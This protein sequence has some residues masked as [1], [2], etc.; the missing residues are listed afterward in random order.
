MRELTPGQHQA[1]DELLAAHVLRSLDGEDEREAERLLAEHVP[2]CDRCRRVLAEFQAL[3]DDLA[4]AVPP[5]DP[6]E[7]LLPRLR[8]ELNPD[9][10]ASAGSS[11]NRWR[12]PRRGVGSWL[13]A[14]AAIALLG[15]TA[16]NAVLNNRLGD[17]T[18][19][20]ADLARVTRLMAQPDAKKI[21]LQGTTAPSTVLLGY[22]EA[23]VAL[24][25]T[26]VRSPAPGS[27]YR[28]WLGDRQSYRHVGD[29]TP[30]DGL[31]I[32]LLEFDPQRFDRIL[33]TEETSDQPG[34]VP[35]GPHRWTA[36]LDTAKE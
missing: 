11:S 1:I 28:L 6:P 35:S 20:Q 17:A 7:L 21:P 4:L 2:G 14:A 16:W 5:A 25:G 23:E 29:F 34:P 13:T 18:D 30:E 8:E 15:L 36:T 19:R 31:V 22:R 10:P 3:A 32:V 26:D 12:S 27:V 24:F 9:I 33:V